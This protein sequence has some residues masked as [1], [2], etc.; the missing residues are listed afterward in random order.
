MFAICGLSRTGRGVFLQ[1]FNDSLTR[2]GGWC[3]RPSFIMGDESALRTGGLLRM[4]KNGQA[5]GDTACPHERRL[6]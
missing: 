2:K 6:S 1:K 5:A 3:G 4:K